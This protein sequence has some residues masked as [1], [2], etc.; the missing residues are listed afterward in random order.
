MTSFTIT[1]LRIH[2]K[3]CRDINNKIA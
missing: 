2:T 1:G 3:K